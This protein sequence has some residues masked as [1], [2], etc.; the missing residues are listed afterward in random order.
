MRG[1]RSI[2]AVAVHAG[3]VIVLCGNATA[4]VGFAATVFA[5]VLLKGKIPQRL[6]RIYTGAA[7]VI[8]VIATLWLRKS[9]LFSSLGIAE[10]HPLLNLNLTFLGVSYAFLRAVRALLDDRRWTVTELARYFFFFPTFFSGPVMDPTDMPTSVPAWD[11]SIVRPGLARILDGVLR[12]GASY[13]LLNFIPLGSRPQLLWSMTHWSGPALW[14]GLFLSGVWLYLNFSGYS[15]VFIGVTTLL[16][17]RPPENFDNPFAATD[18]TSF[19]QRWHISL[20]NWLRTTLYTPLGRAVLGVSPNATLAVG[21]LAPIITMVLC[22]AWHMVAPA[23][24]VWGTLHGLALAVHYLWGRF[25]VPRLP[26]GMR[27]RRGYRT[28]SW[29]VTHAFVAISW[30]FFL[31]VGLSVPLSIRIDLVTALFLMGG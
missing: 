16:A 2:I 17:V 14:M 3:L 31:P 8:L 10:N 19:W 15:E 28:A 1:L 26:G 12:I 22:G 23:F 29:I 9:P 27:N 30:A 7:V 13:L 4:A 20:G 21:V 18:I 6:L 5:L 11:W 24:L 25:V